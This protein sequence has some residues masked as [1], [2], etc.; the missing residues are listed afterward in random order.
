MMD[1]KVG[2]G[3]FNAD[4][5]LR[6]FHGEQ[7]S[8]LADYL[9]HCLET[10]TFVVNIENIQDA[11]RVSLLI[12]RELL[13]PQAGHF[14]ILEYTTGDD[15][16][17]SVKNLAEL[18]G[19]TG[20]RVDRY[21]LRKLP[22]GDA[23]KLLS[24]RGVQR[25][26]E[27]SYANFDGNLRALG[28]LNAMGLTS[29]RP[30]IFDET[31]QIA[32]STRVRI[33]SLSKATQFVLA[34]VVAHRGSVRVDLLHR[35]YGTHGFLEYLYVDFESGVADLISEEMVVLEG[36]I[37]RV[38]HD[39]ISRAFAQ[40]STPERY[41]IIATEAWSRVYTE[42]NT[43]R[44]YVFVTRGETLNYLFYFYAQTDPSRLLRVLEE[45]REVA[46]ES[47]RPVSALNLLQQLWAVLEPRL[48]DEAIA[49][50][51]LAFRLLDVF[52][53]LGLY[54]Q[55]MEIIIK[56]PAG[57]PQ[58]DVYQVALLVVQD[59]DEQAVQLI[60]KL[61]REQS[62][63]EAWYD[64]FLQFFLMVGY[65]CLDRMQDAEK[66]FS[67]MMVTKS[68]RTIPAFGLLLR[69]AEIVMGNRTAIPYLQKSVT[70]FQSHSLPVPQAQSRISL[71]VNFII[72][73]QLE[74][75]EEELDIAEALL[76]DRAVKRH[77]G[78]NDRATIL[79]L[80]AAPDPGGAIQ[81]LTSALRTVTV[82]F[83][84]IVIL[85]NMLIAH[86]IREDLELIDQLSRELLLLVRTHTFTDLHRITYLNLSYAWSAVGYPDLAANYLEQARAMGEQGDPYFDHLLFG[87]VL[88]DPEDEFIAGFPYRPAFLANWDTELAD[89]I[90]LP[91]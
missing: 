87:T 86:A 6:S 70:F 10:R 90:P 35:L 37:V 1:R 21:E 60:E 44:E 72:D 57:M 26:L 48:A 64:F 11:D 27:D 45:V 5:V 66:L 76:H 51:R 80:R 84:R 61:L 22:F 23:R 55:A 2:R 77:I 75:A 67:R 3:E 85:N 68:F 79:L 56:L 39:S 20:S 24:E 43:R 28:D 81:L 88:T 32:D 50:E 83:D 41:R 69:N 91:H 54:E 47:L 38:A 42:L 4:T 78:L 59:Q 13:T 29:L 31:F 12:T 65:R 8:L 30:S 58:R 17:N 49:A 33:E 53:L 34:C 46:L 18:L 63:Q 74:K 19:A 89:F 62:H 71:A 9:K 73:G 36:E 52:Y 15:N 16:P 14:V 7:I 82:A 25:L 40:A